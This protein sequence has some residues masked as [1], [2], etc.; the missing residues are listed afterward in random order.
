MRAALV[1]SGAGAKA[2]L[3]DATETLQQQQTAL[4]TQKGQLA[5]AI[6][7]RRVLDQELRRAYDA[8]VAE[9]SQ[10]LAE[11]E[12]QVDDLEQKVA[13]ARVKTGHMKIVSPIDGTVFGLT[14]TTIG[15][16]LAPSEE[17]MRIV[18]DGTNLEIECYVQNQDIGFVRVGQEAVV[19]IDSFPFTQYGTLDAHVTRV[20]DD[21]I[22][23]PDAQASEANPARTQKSN[24]FGGAQRTQNLVFP[25]TL[26]PGRDFMAVDGRA[27]PLVPGMAVSVEMK[28]GRRRILEYI[29]SPL[30]E[31]ASQAM[32]ER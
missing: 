6:A 3:I 28:T 18:P 22:P 29:F 24:Y 12:R 16:V 14:A 5:E 1:K 4:A 7:A 15:Q 31:T 25:V 30:V 8:F 26:K 10:K 19:K 21:A 13:K 20:G 17:I 2:S 32:K 11:A 23:E 9:N 27:V